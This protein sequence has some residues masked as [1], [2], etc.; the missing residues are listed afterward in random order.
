M[1][2][3]IVVLFVA[4]K[5]IELFKENKKNA[6]NDVNDSIIVLFSMR[7]TMLP[8]KPIRRSAR[9]SSEPVIC[10]DFSEE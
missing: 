10:T 2:L 4:S 7:S 1:F 9:K 8:K 6:D 3:S 5:K